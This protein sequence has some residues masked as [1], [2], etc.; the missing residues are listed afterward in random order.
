VGVVPT[1][2]DPA[3]VG[4]PAVIVP[5]PAPGDPIVGDLT[6]PEDPIVDDLTTADIPEAAVPTA[7]DALK[8]A[9]PS[10]Q[11]E[12]NRNNGKRLHCAISPIPFEIVLGR[13]KST[14]FFS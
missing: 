1:A 3:T 14:I 4:V 13:K 10:E 11:T 2:D 12:K 7:D 5:P 8:K 9:H 6:T